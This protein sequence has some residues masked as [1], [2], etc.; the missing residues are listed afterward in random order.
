MSIKESFEKDKERQFLQVLLDAVLEPIFIFD[1]SGEILLF[2]E[3]SESLLDRSKELR[4]NQ[5]CFSQIE[6]SL[7]KLAR[8]DGPFR[9]DLDLVV[10][11]G[12][13]SV[14]FARL[15]RSQSVRR[16]LHSDRLQSLGLLSGSVAHDFN[17][18]LAGIMG[19]VSYL[20]N[21]LP[22]EGK[23]SQ[24]LEAIEEGSQK[25]ATLTR[26]IL[27][28]ARYDVECAPEPVELNDL[29]R[30][31]VLLLK[32]ALPP[33]IR[34]NVE[35]RDP[36][37]YVLG[38][39]G[40]VAQLL[41]N[42]VVNAR[43]AL[44]GVQSGGEIL[45]RT[46]LV[47]DGRSV[48]LIVSDNGS[49]ICASDLERICDPYFSTKGSEGNGLGLATVMSILEDIGGELE[50]S[51]QEG[52]GATFTILLPCLNS[53][54]VKN[55]ADSSK[56]VD[57]ASV[58]SG[59]ILLIDDEKSVRDA[60]ELTLQAEGYDVTAVGTGSLGVHAACEGPPYDLILL[61]MIMAEMPGIEVFRKLQE[62][63]CNTPVLVMS[64]FCDP[65]DIEEILSK[66]GVGF[67]QKPFTMDVLS[68]KVVEVLRGAGSGA[69]I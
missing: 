32:G 47:K 19:H 10:V 8:K 49:G 11:S 13:E 22:K 62:R 61:D 55:L 7:L 64:G 1:N 17:N 41:V 31:T 36:S 4:I 30:R 26:Q 44:K 29:V 21:V 9:E 69:P 20:Q 33:T 57:E 16:S 67:L 63:G 23:H 15:Q 45:L 43:D 12:P 42:L 53:D 27:D 56:P 24:S 58:I 34:L 48:A 5:A 40:R 28:F 52:E 18:I 35:A 68:G 37:L 51:S 66:G 50:I 60:L 65:K 54:V 14:F 25:A 59:R 39:E 3:L 2:N 38:V 46:E 6:G